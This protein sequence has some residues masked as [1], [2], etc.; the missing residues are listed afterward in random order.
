MKTSRTELVFIL[1][2]SGSMAGLESDTIGGFNSTLEKQKDGKGEAVVTTVLFD[3]AY[4]L[5]HD[6]FDINN[7]KPVSSNDY[8]V[9]GSTALLDAVG[10]T[11]SKI[12]N[13]QRNAGEGEQA[14]K[15][16][17]VI[18]TDGM[19]NASHEYSYS[20]IKKMIQLEKEVYGWEFIFLG[21]NIDAEEVAG[22][23]GINADRA[24][25]YH[26]DSKGLKHS[27]DSVNDAIHE[28]RYCKE[29]SQDWKKRAEKDFQNRK[30]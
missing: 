30:R 22:R 6:R 14:D 12:A 9:R 28:V 3:H 11:I 10:K 26:A 16:M 7:V 8:F 2:R 21:A 27:Y 23:Y 19:E 5:L 24:V 15:V 18:I 13:V 1:D 25:N 20:Q 29:I 17:F 4:E